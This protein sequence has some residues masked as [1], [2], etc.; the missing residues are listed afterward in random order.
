MYCSLDKQTG[1]RRNLQARNA[2]EARQIVE[3]KNIAELQPA[4]NRQ[5]AGACLAGSD[6]GVNPRTW[7][8]G[9][10]MTIQQKQGSKDRQHPLTLP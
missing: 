1:K 6:S 10:E 4:L 3:A 8:D 5:I 2:S 7:L 9:V